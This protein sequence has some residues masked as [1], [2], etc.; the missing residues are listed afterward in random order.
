[1]AQAV[2]ELVLRAVFHR[3]PVLCSQSPC[4]VKLEWFWHGWWRQLLFWGWTP[5]WPTHGGLQNDTGSGAGVR[6]LTMLKLE[7]EPIP[8]TEYSVCHFMFPFTNIT[9]LRDVYFSLCLSLFLTFYLP[10]CFFL[11]VWVVW[12][13]FPWW[14]ETDIYFLYN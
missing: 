10:H 14:V 11:F 2:T 1:M 6:V 12:F 9:L 3:A 13:S 5:S 8:D 4:V 7:T